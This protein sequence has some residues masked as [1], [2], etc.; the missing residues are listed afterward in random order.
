M[1]HWRQPLLI[2]PLLT[3]TSFQ[4]NADE[5]GPTPVESVTS[6]RVNPPFDSFT[7]PADDMI[8]TR[9]PRK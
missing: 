5:G 6:R 7:D 3:R 9:I 1:V 4:V 2:D 8:D